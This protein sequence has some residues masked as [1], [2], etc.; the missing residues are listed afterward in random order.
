M[1]M[2]FFKQK[3][4][5]YLSTFLLNLCFATSAN[6][7][8]TF[9]PYV[10]F[11]VQQRTVNMVPGYGEGLFNKR[12]PQG[13]IYVGFNFHEYFGIEVGQQFTQG[14]TRTAL[15][16]ENELLLR[17][18]VDAGDFF[19]TKGNLKMYG[20]HANI[21]G[22]IPLPIA[23]SHI[24]FSA[25][26]VA[27]QVKNTIKFLASSVGV[28]DSDLS[29]R[30]ALVFSSRRVVPQFSGGLGFE[31]SNNAKIQFLTGYEITS[32]FKNMQNKFVNPIDNTINN[33]YVMSLKNNF[34]YGVRLNFQF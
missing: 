33:T 17:D 27:L 20:A 2:A 24:F 29:E 3:G 31:I 32:K 14:S 19:I 10:G 25:G 28:F 11:D 23:R 34:N 13:N 30:N 15:T 12:V 1:E 16:P 26:A 4:I 18:L 8:E 6:A 21:V 9:K 5:T 7:L 22:H